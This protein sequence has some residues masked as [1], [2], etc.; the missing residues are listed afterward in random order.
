MISR[1]LCC[2][3]ALAALL[4]CPLA[5]AAE[6]RADYGRLKA[7]G[8]VQLDLGFA[9]STEAAPQAMAAL[10]A[11]YLQSVGVYGSWLDSLGEYRSATLGVE[12][13]PLF[14][15]R[16]FYDL[17]TGRPRIDLFVDSLSLRI[18]AVLLDEPRAPQ[19]PGLEAGIGL[20]FPLLPQTQGPWLGASFARRWPADAMGGTDGASQVV[21]VTI[22]WQHMIDFGLIDLADRFE[23]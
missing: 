11:R 6:P 17:Q 10:T 20:S 22:G 23:P 19:T 4:P 5:R 16:F 8:A 7:D 18:G 21:A 9:H 3:L 1:H 12:L 14:L 2:G 13:R 15:P